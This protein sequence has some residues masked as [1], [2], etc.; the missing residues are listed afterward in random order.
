MSLIVETHQLDSTDI[1]NGF[2]SLVD[3]VPASSLNVAM[4][5]V[6][7][8]AQAMNGDFG[9]DGTKIVW[10]STAYALNGQLAA[11]DIVRVLYD[12]S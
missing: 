4:D 1:S 9:V 12:R 5:L 6:Q 10:D 11:Y 3:G 2:L 7:G 8:S